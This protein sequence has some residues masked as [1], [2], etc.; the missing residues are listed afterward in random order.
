MGSV[1]LFRAQGYSKKQKSEYKEQA[2]RKTLEG[3]VK[4]H[5]PTKKL[6]KEMGINTQTN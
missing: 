5:N 6:G 2:G 1:C 4:T 3:M